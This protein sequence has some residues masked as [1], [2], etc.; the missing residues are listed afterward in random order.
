MSQW[1]WKD[2]SGPCPTCS[3]SGSVYSR[4]LLK[5]A[6]RTCPHCLG[7][8]QVVVRTATWKYIPVT[9]LAIAGLVFLIWL[10]VVTMPSNEGI[11]PTP[12][13]LSL[14][15]G[16]KMAMP[17]PVDP[18]PPPLQ[19]KF[20][21]LLQWIATFLFA[22]SFGRAAIYMALIT[23]QVV[24]AI[25]MIL[26]GMLLVL[27]LNKT[28]RAPEVGFKLGALLAGLSVIG[29]AL[30]A[31]PLPGGILILIVEGIFTILIVLPI[32]GVG[33]KWGDHRESISMADGMTAKKQTRQ[34]SFGKMEHLSVEAVLASANNGY[35]LPGG[36]SPMEI[37][38]VWA[39]NELNEDRSP[40]V[41][42]FVRLWNAGNP[43]ALALAERRK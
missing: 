15:H 31:L 27:S 42:D 24:F 26:V 35:R 9:L 18:P 19:E 30:L 32:M 8:K 40:S 23:F 3:G 41:E 11:V 1:I 33:I 29:M 2:V 38:Q 22:D 39:R 34:F 28:E 13:G 4:R 37:Y 36:Y 6:T 17:M 20:V 12:I 10:A 14:A 25:T 21:E 5:F 7:A 43:Q 16:L